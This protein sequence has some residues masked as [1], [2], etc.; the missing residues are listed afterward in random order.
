MLTAYAVSG[1][2]LLPGAALESAIWIDLYRPDAAEVASLA[3]L[4]VEVPTLADME[5][6]ELSN[7]LYHEGDTHVMTVVLTG[8]TEGE[9]RISGPVSFLLSPA[10]LVTVR[11]HN[12]RP[13]ETFAP[14]ADRSAA[15]TG[16]PAAIF[17]GLTEEITGRLA[18]HLEEIGRG[19]DT[20]STT[21][22]AADPARRTQERLQVSL[23][24]VGREGEMLSRLRLSLLTLARAIGFVQPL[25]ALRPLA[26]VATTQTRDLQALEVHADFLGA[27]L[28]LTSDATL[29]MIDL[30]QNATVRIVSVVSVLF[31]PPTLIASIYG[32][33]F[34]VMP[35][36]AQRWGY[37]AAL[38]MMLASAA[39]SWAFFKWKKWL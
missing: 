35:E 19:L 39:L 36:L 32:M 4:G 3:A 18:D 1:E 5:E 14:R 9:A 6:I 30:A 12:P 22:Y 2:R 13:F 11:H 7:R 29:G 20:V 34:A 38:V 10:R 21:I 28:A 23:Q 33:N 25:P 8:Q 17:L 31:L 37:P 15:G 16:S 27:R 24:R 26:D